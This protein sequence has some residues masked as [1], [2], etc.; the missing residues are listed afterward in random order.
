MG[1]LAISLA[2][3][4][5]AARLGLR[6]DL[7]KAPGADDVADEALLFGE[8]PGRVVLTVAAADLDEVLRRLAGLPAA[9]IGEVVAAERLTISRAGKSPSQGVMTNVDETPLGGRPNVWAYASLPRK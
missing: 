4:A 8:T 2:R 3:A 1:G 7:T 9:V 5:L 6:I